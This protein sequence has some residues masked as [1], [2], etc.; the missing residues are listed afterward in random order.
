MIFPTNRADMDTLGLHELD[1][2]LVT[3]DVFI[4]QSSFGSA[5]I[6]RVLMQHNYTVGIIS[7]PDW[8]T[9]QDFE[10][11]GKPRLGFL[12]TSGNID[13]MVNHYSVNKKPRRTDAYTAGGEAGKRPNRAVIVYCSKLREAYG[14][15]PIIIGG[16]EASLRRF[17]HYDYLQETVRRPIL[18]DSQADLLVYGMGEKAII[19]VADSL[20][21]GIDIK[22]LTYL[23]GCG[24][25]VD[26]IPDDS[27]VLP[28]FEMVST[29]KKAFAQSAKEIDGSND[30]YFE[31]PFV[32]GV[33]NRYFLQNV[34]QMPLTT[35]EMDDVYDLPYTGEQLGGGEPAPCIKEVQ[36]SITANRGCLASCAFCALSVHQG[37][38]MQKRSAESILNEVKNLTKAS[39][40]KGYIHDIGGPT[41]NFRNP[42]CQKQLK[43]GVC[44][45]RECLFP[46]VCP[47]IDA[48]ETEYSEI[49]KKAQKV[50]G[51]KKVFVRSGIRY[52]F[53]LADKKSDLFPQIVKHHISGQL[54]VAPEH[55]CPNVLDAM[56]KPRFE[57]YEKFKVAF[58]KH[59]KTQQKNQYVVPYFISSHPGTTLAN[60]VELSLYFKKAHMIPEQV[61]D[62]YPTPGSLATAMYYTGID[63]RTMENIH[64]PLGREKKL[65]RALMQYNKPENYELVQEALEKTGRKDLMANQPNALISK[66]KYRKQTTNQK[67]YHKKRRKK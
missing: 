34:A 17:A 36:F 8:K 43:H 33:G 24:T 61:Q 7:Q 52:D 67:T 13:S 49:L 35:M 10:V 40:F 18:V 28:S 30:P 51:V 39:D 44:R 29:N 60:A 38:Y 2:I 31:H 42:A 9:T 57:V 47:N 66:S 3:G 20:N 23:R 27:I 64:I 37:R 26:E 14:N 50:E 11:L 6:A 62:F 65:Q 25:M 12:V 45:H 56:G 15:V 41:A 19:E 1:F 5:I 46:K 63:P 16:I 21:A 55:I 32:Q 59:N 58:D 53:L 54:R 4:D 22:D 48:D